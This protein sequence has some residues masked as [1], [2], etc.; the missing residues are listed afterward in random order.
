MPRVL[1]RTLRTFGALA[2]FTRATAAAIWWTACA[3]SAIRTGV[4]LDE[5]GDEILQLVLAELAIFVRVEFHRMSQHAIGIHPRS[6]TLTT[7]ASLTAAWT[8]LPATAGAST[9]G[10]A[11][12]TWSATFRTTALCVSTATATGRRTAGS[13]ITFAGTGT[14]AIF[15]TV[16]RTIPFRT[17]TTRTRL[18]RTS[19][20]RAEFVVGQ[21]AVFVLVEL[22]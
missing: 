10:C 18:A 8:A 15:G 6:A 14:G 2:T 20:L 17:T 21:F 5:V 12:A 4:L 11:G 9:T 3:A 13:A 1:L 22:R 19:T 7:R 16:A